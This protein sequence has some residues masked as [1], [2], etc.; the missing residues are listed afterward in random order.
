[1]RVVKQDDKS[2]ALEQQDCPHLGVKPV[3]WGD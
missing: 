2:L 1:M 3:G